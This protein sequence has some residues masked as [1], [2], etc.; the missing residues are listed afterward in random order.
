M[1]TVSHLI[2]AVSYHY[3]NKNISPCL[4]GQRGKPCQDRGSQ[5]QLY[6][7]PA[8]KHF[9]PEAPLPHHITTSA[10]THLQ[11]ISAESQTLKMKLREA[12]LSLGQLL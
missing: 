9:E 11:N 3:K 1:S 7:H 4:P 10:L 6:S 5:S 2:K 8:G 12:P